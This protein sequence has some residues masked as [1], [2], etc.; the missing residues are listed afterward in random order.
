MSKI[1]ELIPDAE[2]LIAMSPEDVGV[3]ILRHLLSTPRYGRA[4]KF[5]RGNFLVASATPARE[6]SPQFF[7]KINEALAGGW[8]WLEREGALLPDPDNQDRDW[9]IVSSRGRQMLDPEKLRAFKYASNFPAA[10]LHPAI[11]P[12]TFSHFMK[13][14]YDT[15]VFA[16]FREVEVAVRRAGGFSD[17]VLGTDLMRQAFREQ[18]GSLTDPTDVISEQQAVQH[19]FAGA[20]GLFKNPSSHRSG[21]VNTPDRAVALVQFADL[22]LRIVDERATAKHSSTA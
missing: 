6:Y 2:T 18:T 12:G 16:A 4:E 14:E 7:D 1:S 5:K 15:A 3:V 17:S 10:K 9:V 11:S 20:I 19:L 8:A 22:L 13:G 21:V